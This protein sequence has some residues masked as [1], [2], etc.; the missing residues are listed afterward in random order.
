RVLECVFSSVVVRQIPGRVAAKGENVLNAGSCIAVEDRSE[1]SARVANARQMG[2]GRK[3]SFLLNSYHQIMRAFPC[4]T[5]RAI[6]HRHERW[7]QFLQA[8]NRAEQLFPRLVALGR[9]ELETER[10]RMLAENVLNVH[11]SVF[12][13]DSSAVWYCVMLLEEQAEGKEG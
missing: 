2:Y 7:L 8:G 11:R 12:V 10:G 4:R 1:L 13:R 9:K 6:R 3:L 5:A